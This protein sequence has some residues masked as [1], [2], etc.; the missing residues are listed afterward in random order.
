MTCDLNCNIVPNN[1]QMACTS[2]HNMPDSRRRGTES[3]L[4]AADPK[5]RAERTQLHEPLPQSLEICNLVVILPWRCRGWDCAMIDTNP[6]VEREPETGQNAGP[7][8]VTIVWSHPYTHR[9]AR[10][11]R[12]SD[13]YTD[14]PKAAPLRA[15]RATAALFKCNANSNTD[16]TQT[17]HANA[18]NSDDLRS[19]TLVHC[20]PLSSAV[21]HGM[22][23]HK[24]K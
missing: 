18:N 16:R 21:E 9:R 17:P 23:L 11:H 1:H 4:P 3:Y 24:Q 5:K 22:M 14:R 19:A 8:D 20:F 10:A 7:S 2:G 6:P 12:H 15:F 13:T